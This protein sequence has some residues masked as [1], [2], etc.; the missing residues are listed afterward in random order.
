MKVRFQKDPSAEAPYVLVCAARRD[1]NV[2]A[3]MESIAAP[4]AICAYSDRGEVLIPQR[5]IQR[6]YTQQRRVLAE[7]DGGT[8]FLKE[9][10]YELEEE[11]NANEFVRI[12]NSEIVNRRRILK[13]DFSLNGTIRM[14]F[15]DGTETYVSRRYV[16]RIRAIFEKGRNGR[17]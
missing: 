2:E 15:R 3:L 10:M 16:P 7:C 6:I 4:E 13:L 8:F 9:R 14:I 5:E 11:L 1:A 17:C 12:S